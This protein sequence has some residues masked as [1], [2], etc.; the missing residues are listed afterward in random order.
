MNQWENYNANAVAL[1]PYNS[2]INDHLKLVCGDILEITKKCGEWVCAKCLT[3]SCIGI[4]P[5]NYLQIYKEESENFDLLAFEAQEILRTIFKKFFGEKSDYNEC[6]WKYIDL[7]QRLIENLP[8]TSQN[9]VQIAKYLDEFRELFG[10]QPVNRTSKGCIMRAHDLTISNFSAK[11]SLYYDF[12]PS[13]SI[14]L[15]I[16]AFFPYDVQ[17][18]PQLIDQAKNNNIVLPSNFIIKERSSDYLVINFVNIEYSRLQNMILTLTFFKI[19]NIYELELIGMCCEKLNAPNREFKIGHPLQIDSPLY[20]SINPNELKYQ[21]ILKRKEKVHELNTK[22]SMLITAIDTQGPAI[23]DPNA[24][25]TAQ[26]PLNADSNYQLNSIFLNSIK[27]SLPKKANNIRLT[28]RA[29]K[30]GEWW[31]PN[32]KSFDP[33]YYVLETQSFTSNI[34]EYGYKQSI[35]Y[36]LRS[37]KETQIEI[38]KM[39]FVF[40]IDNILENGSSPLLYFAIFPFT[41]T[42]NNQT[43]N[44]GYY[45]IPIYSITQNNNS[46]L[47]INSKDP[48]LL[49]FLQ[50]PNNNT[51]FKKTEGCI[52]FIITSCSTCFSS[53]SEITNLLNLTIN[54][55]TQEINEAIQKIQSVSTPAFE[56][57]M[58]KMFAVICRIIVEAH[59]SINSQ[60]NQ[61]INIEEYK[62]KQQVCIEG[63]ITLFR[64]IDMSR[65]DLTRRFF[66]YFIDLNI[67]QFDDTFKDLSEPLLSYLAEALPSD[68][69]SINQAQS[70]S[71]KLVCRCLSYIL[72]FI[73]KSLSLSLSTAKTNDEYKTKFSRSMQ[74]IFKKLAKMMLSTNQNAL[75][76][77]SFVVRSFP[78]LCD[79]IHSS[80]PLEEAYDLETMLFKTITENQSLVKVRYNMYE[81]FC[82][83]NFFSNEKERSKLLPYFIQCLRDEVTKDASCFQ[84]YIYPTIVTLFFVMMRSSSNFSSSF[85]GL[86]PFVQHILKDESNYAFLI[87]MIY[88]SDFDFVYTIIK[89]SESQKEMFTKLLSTVKQVLLSKPAPYIFFISGSVFVEI[90]KINKISAVTLDI[91]L[92]SMV[93]MVSKFCTDFL[94]ELGAFS[95][96]DHHFYTRLYSIDLAPVAAQLPVLLKGASPES[97]FNT[98]VLMPLFHLYLIQKDTREQVIDGFFLVVE[99]DW[100]LNN[101][102]NRSE[103]AILRALDSLSSVSNIS[104]LQYLFKNTKER[105]FGQL[106]Q[107]DEKIKSFFQRIDTMTK[108]IYNLSETPDER[109][110]EDER[111]SAIMKLMEISKESGD[112]KL[113]LEFANKLYKQHISL[114]NKVEAAEVLMKIGEL[115]DFK[116]TN[117]MPEWFG[118]ASMSQRHQKKHI[119]KNA[120]QLFYECEFYERQM[121]ALK[122]IHKFNIEE[123]HDYQSTSEISLKLSACYHSIVQERPHLNR[124]YGVQFIGDDFNMFYRNKTF[125][126]R[127]DSFCMN[128]GMINEIKQKFPNINVST[129]PPQN[130]EKG[131]FIFVFTVK[132]DNMDDQGAVDPF[133]HPS[134]YLTKELSC[135]RFYSEIPIRIRLEDKSIGEFG[136]WHVRITHYRTNIQLQGITR[137]AEVI[138]QSEP[139]LLSPIENAILSLNNKTYELL[140]EAN[141]FWREKRLGLP[142]STNPSHFIMTINGIVN[143]AVNG[144]IKVYTDLFFHKMKD[145]PINIKYSP[146]FITAVADQMRVVNYAIIVNANVLKESMQQ[147]HGFIVVNFGKLL[148]ELEEGPIGKIDYSLPTKFGPIPPTDFLPVQN[149]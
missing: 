57:F 147:L 110:F 135:D 27:L 19:K 49:S 13:L 114:K 10:L 29:F 39:N 118:I 58:H 32:F 23:C 78:V 44:H 109:L 1:F 31:L 126:Y 102:F 68:F 48:N 62:I 74:S 80:F 96:F 12:K 104:D 61:K 116:N 41:S 45:R 8:I 120:A 40:L 89:E 28:V 33:M 20:T 133:R 82:Q 134:F 124:F 141:S 92:A 54:S 5:L 125:I 97:R 81:R 143:A 30:E 115:F 73:S 77:K 17:V 127:R 103:P 107:A 138:Q 132:M 111:V 90:M 106:Q 26:F 91:E 50:D 72:S 146:Q 119:Y 21:N 70:Q 88:F 3:T 76:N 52:S 35:E 149:V 16:K 34:N 87:T 67:T 18:T 36:E 46:P 131:P 123:D 53:K 93:E 71:L 55:T 60:D 99:T 11:T 51:L 112:Q 113:Y 117:I 22:I 9:R 69:E 145:D 129:K 6:D 142:L 15:S 4:C 43:L 24:V 148:K 108:C 56:I 140:I 7:A 66:N 75:I 47:I 128:D 136:E 130:D 105:K 79:I 65:N 42:N 63:L 14:K 38:E 101:N 85:H 139:A 122:E 59:R 84:N 86:A 98:N 25:K 83:T 37:D 137:R 2:S 144:G 64:I 95:Q 94:S 121:D 100:R